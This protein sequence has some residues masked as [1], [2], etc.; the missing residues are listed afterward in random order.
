VQD[1]LYAQ[2]NLNSSSSFVESF[3]VSCTILMALHGNYAD[4]VLWSMK[5][6][7]SN[8]NTVASASTSV[9]TDSMTTFFSNKQQCSSLTT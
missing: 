7:I 9:A 2:R 1:R 6:C 4:V 5:C 8:H 3:H